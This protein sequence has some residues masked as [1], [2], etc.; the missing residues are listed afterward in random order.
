MT[1]RTERQRKLLDSFKYHQPTSTQVERISNIR[2]GAIAFAEIILENTKEDPDQT[3]AIR[4]VHE[5]MMTANKSIVNEGRDAARP[6]DT[7]V[8]VW[9][10]SAKSMAQP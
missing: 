8:A 10:A 7:G 3:V 1:E 5:G 2:K 4:K 9:E 6:L